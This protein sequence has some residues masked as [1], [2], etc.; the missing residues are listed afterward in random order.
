MNGDDGS[1]IWNKTYT[2]TGGTNEF[3]GVRMTI[4]GS[5]GYIYAAGFIGGDEAGTIFI[6][7]AGQEVIMKI[8]PSDGSEIW[9]NINPNSE[10]S[11]ALVESSNNYI[12]SSG[13]SWEEDLTITNK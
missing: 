3:D 7:Y 2:Y 10:Y 8:D 13:T 9:I 5:D 12:F 4:I 11:V 1:I 6:V